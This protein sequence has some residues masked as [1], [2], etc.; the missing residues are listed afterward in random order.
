AGIVSA[1]AQ[2]VIQHERVEVG[3]EPLEIMPLRTVAVPRIGGKGGESKTWAIPLHFTQ[4]QLAVSK[5]ELL[6]KPLADTPDHRYLE[7][8]LAMF[9]VNRRHLLWNP[10][11]RDR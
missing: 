6:G 9:T 7:Q 3:Y 5:V 10:P 11:R 4:R 8:D 1:F 2:R